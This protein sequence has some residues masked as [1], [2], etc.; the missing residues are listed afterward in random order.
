M[1]PLSLTVSFLNEVLSITAQESTHSETATSP[2]RLLLNEV[3]SITA[4]ECDTS[5]PD[6]RQHRSILNE[7]LSITAQEYQGPTGRFQGSDP[8]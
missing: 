3:L 1:V 4:Q 2:N 5:A 8:Q 7:V 6:P